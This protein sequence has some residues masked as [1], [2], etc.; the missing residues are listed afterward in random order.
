[1]R[2]LQNK[3][4]VGGLC[5]FI[6]AVFAFLLLPGIN[7]SKGNTVMVI[8]LTE[9]IRVGT[10]IEE[11][12]LKEVE[13]GSFGLPESIVKEKSQIVGKF[14]KGALT[15]D[16]LLLNT[17]F[18]EYASDDRLDK[19]MAE[20][21]KLVSVTV[22]SNAASVANHLKSGDIVS[23][24]CYING[25]EVT[26]TELK[27]LEIYSVENSESVNVEQVSEDGKNI[28]ETLTLVVDENQAQKLIYAEYSGKL[29]VLF[30]KRGATQ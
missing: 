15:I 29:H 6:A 28:A 21:K 7:K 18:S 12:M 10:K 1:L 19:I 17:K 14:T 3:I 20:G 22:S 11:T 5:I 2:I 16:E 26:F 23:I 4:V 13:V 30:E 25:N 8:K 24:I 9:N 27:N